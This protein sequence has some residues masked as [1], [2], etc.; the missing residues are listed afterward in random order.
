MPLTL[1]ITPALTEVPP[2]IL[3]VEIVTVGPMPLPVPIWISLN[4]PVGK[5]SVPTVRAVTP[6]P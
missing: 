4:S 1:L 5:M 2:P 3:I 6:G